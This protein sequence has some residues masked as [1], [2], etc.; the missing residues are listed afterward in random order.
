MT[1]PGDVAIL[2]FLKLPLKKQRHGVSADQRDVR[3]STLE[4]MQ[5]L[6]LMAEA[7][8]AH[9]RRQLSQRRRLTERRGYVDPNGRRRSLAAYCRQLVAVLFVCQNVTRLAANR[10]EDSRVRLARLN[11]LTATLFVDISFLFDR[12]KWAAGCVRVG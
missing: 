7:K 12:S 3:T 11:K 2:P 8:T 6:T 9:Q 10:L 1:Q 5:P 4:V